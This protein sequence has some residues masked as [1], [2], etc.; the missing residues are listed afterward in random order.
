[1]VS[2]VKLAT[3]FEECNTEEQRSVVP[4]LWAKWLN[5]KDIQ[6]EMFPVYGGKCLSHK[7]FN[8][9]LEEFSQGRLKAA[10]DAQP[11]R[12][13]A[14]V[15]DTTVKRLPMLQVST[16]WQSDGTS[17]SMLAE[18]M[19]RNKCFFQV[20]K[21]NALCCISICDLFTESPWYTYTSVCVCVFYSCRMSDQVSRPYGTTGKIRPLCNF[22]FTFFC[23]QEIGRQNILNWNVGN[24]SRM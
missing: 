20:R 15:V 24:I 21:S 6:K 18:D 9:W 16:H 2:V 14:Q 3:V 1:M 10:D 17:V 13:V 23:C 5:A 19:S 8:N 7:P 4:F 12:P 11:S 22:N